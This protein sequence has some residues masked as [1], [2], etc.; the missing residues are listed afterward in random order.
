MSD[1]SKLSFRNHRFQVYLGLNT[2]VLFLGAIVAMQAWEWATAI[3]TGMIATGASAIVVFGWVAYDQAQVEQ[4][5]NMEDFGYVKAFPHRSIQIKGEYV[6]RLAGAH[7]SIDVMA[8][9]LN[10]LRQDFLGDF[11]GWAERAEVRILLVAPEAPVADWTYANQRDLEEGSHSGRTAEEIKAFLADTAG[12]WTN[13]KRF[14]VRL[15]LSLPSV[16]LFRID[17]EVFWGPYLVS[18]MRYGKP[19]RNLPTLIVK[20]PGYMYHRLVDHFDEIWGSEVL[21]REPNA[22]DLA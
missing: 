6:R 5:R 20:R 19:S 14:R 1:E 7:E 8:Y 3:G 17:D 21:S 22:S 4:R 12:L 13:S 9:G 18:S 11:S 2:L 10:S 16:N 15:A